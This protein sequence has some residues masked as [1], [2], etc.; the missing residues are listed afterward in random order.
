MSEFF[1]ALFL[2]YVLYRLASP[3]IRALATDPP[4]PLDSPIRDIP[5]LV[6]RIGRSHPEAHG[7]RVP[8]IVVRLGVFMSAAD[9]HVDDRELAV[10]RSMF[11]RAG[12]PP[13]IE[14]MFENVISAAPREKEIPQ[15]LLELRR[16][17]DRDDIEIVLH[18][19]LQIIGADG[20]ADDNEMQFFY[21]I[22]SG[23]GLTSDETHRIIVEAVGETRGAEGERERGS[24]RSAYETL[25]LSPTASREEVRKTYRDLARKYH[26]DRV[27]HL[28]PEF[29]ELANKRMSEINQAYET[30]SVST[31]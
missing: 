19:L 7:L 1:G 15:L 29:Q 31:G 13:V 27:E 28:G 17:A 4:R 26:P 10:I 14:R 23:L 12:A 24:G 3:L 11:L 2:I 18:A 6:R 16:I 8:I 22:A 25:G 21:V 20:R 9:G 30:L 5:E